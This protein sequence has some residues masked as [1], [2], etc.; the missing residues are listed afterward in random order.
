MH[1]TKN[2]LPA[3]VRAKVAEILSARL[4]DLIDL[5]LQAKHAHWNVKGPNFIALH[6]LFDKVAE[7][8]EDAVDEVAERI[9]QLGG[10]ADG[11]VQ[12]VAG[13][14]S[15]KA[16]PAGIAEGA[17]HVEALASAMAAAV[18]KVRADID[19]TAE[20]KD[21]VTADVLTGIG[22][23]LDKLLWFVEAHGQASR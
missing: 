9:V 11:T 16:Y 12:A 4:A 22:G 10:T 3:D 1:K 23:E 14:T 13:R 6:E 20:L 19:R 21:S 8:A 5:H 18:S 15:L 7:G 2:D 17:A